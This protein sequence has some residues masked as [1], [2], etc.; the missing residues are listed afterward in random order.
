VGET[1]VLHVL[2]FCLH[3]PSYFDWGNLYLQN[4]ARLNPKKYK[5]CDRFISK[6]KVQTFFQFN[7]IFKRS[8]LKSMMALLDLLIHDIGSL[9]FSNSSIVA[10]V[11]YLM[12]G[13]DGQFYLI[14][15]AFLKNCT[16]FHIH[17]LKDCLDW[18]ATF[19]DF[20]EWEDD[21]SRKHQKKSKQ[22]HYLLQI[23]NPSILP[24]LVKM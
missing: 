8:L 7:P 18:I 6:V 1:H 16:A 4:A 23:H 17:Q 11:F 14:V 22:W 24:G 3:F 21:S 9:Q 10:S 12:T 15:E 13:L 5:E 2:G 19:K 20:Y